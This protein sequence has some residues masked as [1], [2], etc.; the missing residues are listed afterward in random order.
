MSV[1]GIVGSEA[2]ERGYAS[3]VTPPVDLPAEQTEAVFETIS[4]W[5]LL[6]QDC[7]IA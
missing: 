6:V 5:N 2:R 4:R 1:L 7:G 3:A